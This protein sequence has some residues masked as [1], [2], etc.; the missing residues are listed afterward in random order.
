MLTKTTC[1]SNTTLHKVF[2][3]DK[4]RKIEAGVFCKELK[5]LGYEECL[6][7]WFDKRVKHCCSW[8]GDR[9]K[10]W[11]TLLGLEENINLGSWD[12]VKLKL[13]GIFTTNEME[14]R[15]PCGLIAT[16]TRTTC[17]HQPW[18]CS[19]V[20]V[21]FRL[22]SNA[23]LKSSSFSYHP[24]ERQREQALSLSVFCMG[25]TVLI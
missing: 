17:D 21:Q 6:I 11:C 3:K 15:V 10:S 16:C 8:W 4:T 24:E 20:S 22:A 13:T 1:E 2:V 7:R 25:K 19:V 18:I 12:Y 9:S 23:T 14:K 5:D